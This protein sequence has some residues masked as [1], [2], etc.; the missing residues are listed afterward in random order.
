MA[1]FSSLMLTLCGGRC[2]TLQESLAFT[3]FSK[4]GLEFPVGYG[5]NLKIYPAVKVYDWCDN[6]VESYCMHKLM[7]YGGAIP[8][9]LIWM[10]I[11]L[12]CGA[13]YFN[14]ELGMVLV[15]KPE[16]NGMKIITEKKIDTGGGATN[17]FQALFD[18]QSKI[19]KETYG[20]NIDYKEF[21][22]MQEFIGDKFINEFGM[23]FLPIIWPMFP[24]YFD[25]WYYT[26]I[27]RKG[28]KG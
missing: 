21:I 26:G 8:V 11:T 27:L 24:T 18:D 28:K 2:A 23:T 9:E 12:A 13:L 14:R 17:L 19:L 25:N 5:L 20:D 6:E 16:Q 7:D 15:I 4:F 1:D 22:K 3:G 10:G